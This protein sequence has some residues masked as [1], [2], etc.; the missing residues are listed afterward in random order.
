MPVS[1]EF[2]GGFAVRA[3]SHRRPRVRSGVSDERVISVLFDADLEEWRR[4]WNRTAGTP[5][6]REAIISAND[7]T[8][9][10]DTTTQILPGRRLAYTVLGSSADVGQILEAVAGHLKGD[11]GFGLTVVIDDIAP[12]L[13]D[14]DRRAVEALIDGLAETL[15]GCHGSVVIGCSLTELT[16][17]SVAALFDPRTD[18]DQINHPV[19]GELAALR[20]DDPT[21]FGYV[22]R[23]WMEARTGIE[24]CERNYSQAKQVHAMLSEPETTPRTL[25]MTLSGLVTL[26]VLQTWGETVGPTRYDLTAYDPGRMWAVG[27]ALATDR[28]DSAPTID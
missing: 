5:P 12:L 27:A 26:G 6:D 3:S 13:V 11:S 24:R 21:T 10:C 19:V 14:D 20:R 17:A 18:V 2:G 8:R 9:G 4:G 16:A 15:D 1:A 7:P 23:H 25:G 22:R 28:T